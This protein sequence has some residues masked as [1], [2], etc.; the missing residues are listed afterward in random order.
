MESFK[1]L[2][3]QICAGELTE[4]EVQKIMDSIKNLHLEKNSLEKTKPSEIYTETL[5]DPNDSEYL[6]VSIVKIDLPDTS[7][8]GMQKL[9]LK[10]TKFYAERI[11]ISL[12]KFAKSRKRYSELGQYGYEGETYTEDIGEKIDINDKGKKYYY[13]GQFKKGTNQW[14]GIG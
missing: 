4:D 3:R 1:V 9:E 14:D 6:L 10:S 7:K 2:Q 12:A 11:G 13:I 5:P 8:S